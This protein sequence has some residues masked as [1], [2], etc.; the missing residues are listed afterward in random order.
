MTKRSIYSL[1]LA[2]ILANLFV[3]GFFTSSVLAAPVGITIAPIRYK[4]ELKPGETFH[5]S[6]TVSNPNDT[7]LRV[8]AEF[9]DFKVTEGNNIQ[10]LPSDIENPFS[11]QAWVEIRRDIITL[12]PKQELKVPF[13]VTVPGNATAGGHYAALFFRSVA[14]GESGNIGAVPRVGALIITNVAGDVRKSGRLTELK[15]PRFVNRG[16]VT[17]AVSFLNTGTT[18]FET[19]AEVSI[20]NFFWGTDSITSETKFMYPNIARDLSVTWD[21]KNLFGVY[22]VTA[23][24]QDGQGNVTEQSQVFF[25]FPLLQTVGGAVILLVLLWL[26]RWFK[27]RFRLVK[28]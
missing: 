28:V 3:F 26:I 12:G 20:K 7:A 8:Q 13:T 16:P 25:G 10:W 23:K 4:L 11:M 22:T 15:I 9:Q 5:E 17:F 2:S 6:I 19:K 27:K 21:K 1:G 24:I 14:E 18:H